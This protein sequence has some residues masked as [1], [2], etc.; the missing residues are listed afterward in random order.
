MPTSKSS[1]VTHLSAYKKRSKRGGARPGAGRPKG[2]GPYGEATKPIRI[3]L[4]RIN[5]VM[6]LITNENKQDNIGVPL[7]GSKVAAGAPAYADD[8]LEGSLDLNAYLVNKPATTFCVRVSGDS[9]I[10]AGIHE[11]D[12]LVVDR[13]IQPSHGKIVIAAIDGELTVKRL[14]Q[15]SNETILMPENDAYEPIPISDHNDM[16]IWGVVTSVI[17]KV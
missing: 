2:Q 14:H 9:M 12:I 15:T 11:D 7:F 3:P 4:S 10:K 13:S 17:H 8:Y 5:E 1:K 16:M 6:R